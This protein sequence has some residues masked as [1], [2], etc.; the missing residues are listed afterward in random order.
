MNKLSWVQVVGDGPVPSPSL[1]GR[2]L[3]RQLAGG[4]WALVLVK[5]QHL[6]DCLAAALVPRADHVSID[7]HLDDV[8]LLVCKPVYAQVQRRKR[9]MAP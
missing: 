6:G 7:S 9:G 4:Q 3:V 2:L 5:A 8:Q 1:G